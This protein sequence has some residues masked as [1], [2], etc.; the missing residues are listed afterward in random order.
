[1]TVLFA[2]DT[3]DYLTVICTVSTCG[4]ESSVPPRYRSLLF[5]S[6]VS[7]PPPPLSAVSLNNIEQGTDERTGCG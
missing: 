4:S 5:R 7:P 1:M 2:D 3:C 6:Q